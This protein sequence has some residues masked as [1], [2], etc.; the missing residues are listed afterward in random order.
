KKRDYRRDLLS[1][2]LPLGPPEEDVAFAQ[3]TDALAGPLTSWLDDLVARV[4]HAHK[5]AMK[6]LE[7]ALGGLT[8]NQIALKLG[9]AVRS[10]QNIKQQMLAAYEAVQPEE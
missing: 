8:N 5:L 3:T 9:I 10:G 7:M 1:D 4:R 2:R 6:I